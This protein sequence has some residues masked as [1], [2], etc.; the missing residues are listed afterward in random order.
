M[1]EKFISLKNI[2]RFVNVSPKGDVS[3]RKLTLIYGENGRGKTTLCSILRSLVSKDSS[4]IDERKTLGSR[5]DTHCTVRIS[6][7]NCKF[8]NGKWD[9]ACPDI[10][11]F[12]S[13]FVHKNVHTGDVVEHQHKKNLFQVIVGEKG[14][15]HNKKINE[16]NKLIREANTEI[17]LKGKDIE[18]FIPDGMTLEMFIKLEQVEKIDEKVTSIQ[19]ELS[20]IQTQ[21]K[22]SV[23]IQAKENLSTC[24]LP[25]FPGNFEDILNKNIEVIDDNAGEKVKTHLA[26]CIL[27]PNETWLSQG[28]ELIKEELCP[29]CGQSIQD[30]ELITAYRTYFNQEYNQLK[31]NVA[32]LEEQIA[33]A[34]GENKMFPLQKVLSDNILVS[35]FWKNHIPEFQLSDISFEEIQQ[36]YS[37]L[38]KICLELTEI[39][40]KNPLEA[41]S[42]NRDYKN[43]QDTIL[44]IEEKVNGYNEFVNKLNE[45]I[46]QF[47]KCLPTEIDEKNANQKLIEIITIKK[48]FDGETVKA[49]EAYENAVKNKTNLEKQKDEEKES[50]NKYC[51]DILTK[52]EKSINSYLSEFNTGFYVTQTKPSYLGG[53]PSSQYQLLIN[54]TRIGLEKFKITMSSGDRNSLALAFFLASLDHDP[55][56]SSKV[57]ALDDPFTSLDR[58]RRECTA[59]LCQQLSERTKQVIVLSHDPHFLKLIYDKHNSTETKTLQL[60]KFADGSVIVE[61][62]I[63]TELQSGYMKNYSTLLAY[64]RNSDGDKLAVARSIRPFIEGLLRTHFPGHFDPNDWLGDFIKKI[65]AADDSS[66]LS[67]AK[68]DLTAIESI[69]EF[70]K[71]FHH[72]QNPNADSEI[73]NEGE[74]IGYTKRTLALVGGV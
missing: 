35:A 39:K 12:D 49:I 37:K 32:N 71:K 24:S 60:P 30:N 23:S 50:L 48:R 18:K 59:Q 65:R 21:I 66:G 33:S 43:S 29:F 28:T 67:H 58:F 36:S 54:N 68:Q 51:I 53:S 7:G 6:G 40:R 11:V 63:E 34:I 19:N 17:N 20:R 61:W 72:D 31:E 69:N 45:K 25:V 2:G 15:E 3:F 41:V 27:S 8:T 4:L 14:V 42:T 56:L 44:I 47:K 16:L 52:Y 38:R 22:E 55:N 13:D 26:D 1:I 57:V 70:S 5:S 74:L 73:I 10:S 46:S 9:I 64:Y 62:D